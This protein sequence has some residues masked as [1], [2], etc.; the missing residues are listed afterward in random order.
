VG[1]NVKVALGG[2]V[3]V[4]LGGPVNVTLGGSVKG[5][6]AVPGLVPNI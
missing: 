1:D 2:S 4:A 5:G 3:K 6:S